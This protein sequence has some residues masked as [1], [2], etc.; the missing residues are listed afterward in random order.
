MFAYSANSEKNILKHVF[1]RRF[2]MGKQI[3][4]FDRKSIAW[5]CNQVAKM[6]DNTSIRFD[7]AVQRTLVWNQ[8]RKSLLIH[9]LIIGAPIPPMYA[10]RGSDKIYDFLDGKQRCN[11][12]H[13]YLRE[14]YPLKDV[15]LIQ[16]DDGSEEDINGLYFS[17]LS[18]EMKDNIKSYTLNI[19]YFDEIDEEQ[20]EELFFR[21]NN[22]MPLTAIEKSRVKCPALPD[23][24]NLCHHPVFD[25]L[26]DKA[27]ARYTDEDIVIKC[28]AMLDMNEPCLNTKAI[29]TFMEQLKID[30]AKHVK[31][32]GIFDTIKQ[33]HDEMMENGASAVAKRLYVKTH[34]ISIIPFVATHGKQTEFLQE[35]FNGKRSSISQ[36]YNSNATSGVGHPHR[37]RARI[38]AIET[39]WN[40]FNHEESDNE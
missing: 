1:L 4:G 26:S 2:K 40:K 3:I 23:V 18:E 29:R 6:I 32:Y 16:Y 20:Q 11:A 5:N 10:V 28:I 34:L 38:D 21:L 14:I 24:Q 33:M 35:F 39:E 17:G 7:N 19:N 22:G 27:R 37:V 31:M 30:D 36:E 13:D 9:S 12:I 8:Q 25:S 15:P